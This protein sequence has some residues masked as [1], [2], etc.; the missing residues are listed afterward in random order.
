MFFNNYPRCT[1]LLLF[2]W[3]WSCPVLIQLCIITSTR[4]TD[5]RLEVLTVL[6]SIWVV[7]LACIMFDYVHC[8]FLLFLSLACFY[9]FLLLW[10]CC[11][12]NKLWLIDWLIYWYTLRTENKKAVLSQENRAMPR[13]IYAIP[14]SIP[15]L[16]SGW[17]STSVLLC[18]PPDSEDRRI[19]FM[20][21]SKKNS[22]LYNHGTPKTNRQ[23]DG[24]LA[25]A[26]Q[27]TA[28]HRSVKIQWS[29]KT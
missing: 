1:V 15:R 5:S 26:W 16:I 21:F 20:Y 29:I 4:S 7:L 3:S 14:T 22:K 19:I 9:S 11:V 2:Y 24:R 10:T 17:W 27:R 28:E 13:V 25:K 23:T 12:W 8:L 6:C 18:M